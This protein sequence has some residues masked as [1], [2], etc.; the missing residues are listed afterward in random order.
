M[1]NNLPI[2]PELEACVQP[3]EEHVPPH[4]EVA[5]VPYELGG[6]FPGLFLFT[7]VARMMR[8]VKQ[9]GERERG[10]KEVVE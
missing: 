9:V 5:Y 2:T 8:P 4:L 7:Q 10:G 3:G 6:P 1:A